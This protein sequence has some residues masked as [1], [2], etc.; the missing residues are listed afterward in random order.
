[1]DK[2]RAVPITIEEARAYLAAWHRHH[3]E[4]H[5]A[6]FAQAV[7]IDER[8]CGVA[9][10][11]NRV[12]RLA[13]REQLEVVRLATDGTANACSRLQAVVDRV[14]RA[15]GY[16]TLVTFTL[17][18]EGGASLRAS[19]WRGPFPTKAGDWASRPNRKAGRQLPKWK[20][21]RNVAA[22]KGPK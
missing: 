14:A 22:A 18:E 13:S 15:K 2:W 11:G 1:M 16:V 8:I 17:P 3:P 20:W 10:C 6:R 4:C 7:A 9:F 12:A 5:A 21:I 19:N